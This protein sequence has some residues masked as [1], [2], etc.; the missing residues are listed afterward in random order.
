[1]N[2]RELC[3][4]CLN[5][6]AICYCAEL[7]P[8][9]AEIEI[10]ILQHPLERKRSIGSARMTHLSISNSRLIWGSTFSRNAV[11]NALIANAE[12]HCVALYPGPAS[13]PIERL[14]P[15]E[16]WPTGKKLVVFVIDGTWINARKM[17][18]RSPNLMALPQICFM[19]GRESQYRFRKQPASY[20]LSTLEAVHQLLSVLD[21]KTD[22][23]VLL[24][25]FGQLVERQVG[26]AKKGKIRRVESRNTIGIS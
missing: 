13:V 25:L 15:G 10:V 2:Q 16:A 7:R 5:A 4:Q 26:Y 3:L 14:T 17:M 11:V 9:R 19:P 1:V 18:Q 6:R 20:C 23:S 8:F 12:N 22:A 24:R 21:P